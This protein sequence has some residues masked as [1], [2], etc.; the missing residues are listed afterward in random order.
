M[1]YC[2][3]VTWLNRHSKISNQSWVWVFGNK[4]WFTTK[5]QGYRSVHEN[6]IWPGS[7]CNAVIQINHVSSWISAKN[8]DFDQDKQPNKCPTCQIR[9]A[10]WLRWKFYKASRREKSGKQLQLTKC[11]RRRA[12]NHVRHVLPSLLPTIVLQVLQSCQLGSHCTI[13]LF[14]RNSYG[15]RF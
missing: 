5:S 15:C 12:V 7:Y 6:S 14:R 8:L 10:D 4:L 1:F 11:A 3:I 2:P 13:W 9:S